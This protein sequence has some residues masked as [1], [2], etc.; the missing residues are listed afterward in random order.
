MNEK[1]WK[2]FRHE[3]F[4]KKHPV[5]KIWPSDPQWEWKPLSIISVL[6]CPAPSA[7][8][9]GGWQ[10]HYQWSWI[11]NGIL[12]EVETIKTSVPWLFWKVEIPRHWCSAICSSTKRKQSKQVKLMI[13]GGFKEVF[14]ECS[15]TCFSTKREQTGQVVMIY[16]DCWNPR[17]VIVLEDRNPPGLVF[18]GLFLH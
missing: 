6:T 8:K 2:C 12:F 15:A 14:N 10:V 17:A 13:R 7:N 11:P 3:N 4:P 16:G 18:R 5:Q 1:K 9:H